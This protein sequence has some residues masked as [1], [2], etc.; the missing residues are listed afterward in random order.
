M[1]M[2]DDVG[3][4][5]DEFLMA[6]PSGTIVSCSV[7]AHDAVLDAAV[8]NWRFRRQGSAAIRTEYARWFADPGTFEHLRR[9]PVAGGEVVAYL[10]TWV[11]NGVPHAAH[12]MYVLDVREGKIVTDAVLCGGRWPAGLLA[13]MQA[14]QEAQDSRV[15]A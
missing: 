2:I 9:L 6:V 8:P 4:P 15:D 13:E 14:A 11:E 3:S 5:I 10:L 7:R 12:H 1:G